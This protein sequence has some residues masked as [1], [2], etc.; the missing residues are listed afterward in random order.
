MRSLSVCFAVPV[1]LCGCVLNVGVESKESVR[2]DHAVPG[3]AAAA[4][5]VDWREAEK[6]ILE[7]HVQLTFSDRFVKAGEAYFSP[8]GARI[9]FQAV[10]V[11]DEGE[12]ADEFYAMYVADLVRNAAG[13][14][15]GIDNIKR[16]SPAGS[17]NTCGWF[18]PH[19]PALVLFA[20]T[21]APPTESSP[22][23]FNRSS[24]RYRWMFPPEM[25]IVMVGMDEADGTAAPLDVV[26]ERGGAYVAEGALSPDGRHV[27]FCSLESG[28]GDL[29]VKNLQT[30]HV[31]PVVR[32]DG[33]DGG[34]FFS[35]DGRRICYRSD[36]HGNHLLQLFVADLAISDA[37]EVTGRQR[38]YQLT[39]NEHVN[40][41]PFWHP[42]GRHL[43]YSTSEIGHHNYEIFLLDADP[44]DLP[45][46]TGSV[47]YGT[48]KQRVT[49]AEGSDVLPVFNSDA[50][51]MMWTSRR[52]NDG[53]V[54]LWLADF[55]LDLD[56]VRGTDESRHSS[57]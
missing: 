24:G 13:R 2:S 20:T 9:I 40:W 38:E 44:G 41:C 51:M 5:P 23:G 16:I 8:N 55:V 43:V 47:K 48:R 37:G 25:R 28:G 32:V 27:V 3:A 33:Y 31:A 1:V 15:T 49:H 21:M 6:G 10:E 50:T 30:G 35:P 7:N 54:Q 53:S 19:E 36:R 39:D 46:S 17:A 34:P 11:P 18:H 56:P 29:F 26:V 52:S 4:D 45:G 12:P 57:R 42:D 14:V 22:P